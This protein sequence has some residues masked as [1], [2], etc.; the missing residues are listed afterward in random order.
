MKQHSLTATKLRV[1]LSLSIFFLALLTSVILYFAQDMLD[2][3]ATEVSHTVVDANASQNNV[4]TLQKIQRELETEKAAVER[5]SS[6]VA[7]SQSYQYQDQILTDL[8]DYASRAGITI[9]NFDFSANAPAASGSTPAVVPATPVPS[10]VKSTSVSVTLANPVVYNN[11]LRFIKSI[12]Q[13]LTKM[14]ISKVSLAKGSGN[15]ISS[16]MLTIEVYIR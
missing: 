10:G 13:N 2:T 7:E 4:Q 6:I 15:D 1:M 12:E 8:N 3:Y 5:A 16:E 11:L 14:Q 9:S